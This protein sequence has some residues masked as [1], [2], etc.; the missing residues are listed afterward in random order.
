VHE[1][2]ETPLFKMYGGVME[3]KVKDLIEKIIIDNGYLLDE[4]LYIEE[5]GI[6]FLRIIIDKEGFINVNDCVT[7]N[8]LI[9]PIIDNLDIEESFILDVCSKTKGSI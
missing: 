6:K 1:E 3:E 7:V 5:D 2:W 8:N 9:D 4:V